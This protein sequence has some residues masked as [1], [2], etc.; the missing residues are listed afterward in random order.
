MAHA[1]GRPV[2][3]ID[4]K[5]FESLCAIQCTYEEICSVLDV[6]DK[7]L[8][9]WCKKTYG[10]SFSEIFGIKRQNGKASLRRM[11]WKLAEKN[12]SMAIFLGKNILNQRDN[13]EVNNEAEL[14]KLDLLL[15]EIRN[16]AGVQN[17]VQS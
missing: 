16:S 2:K 9:K 17:G 10:K 13:I 3:E 5:T 1:G 4:R 14:S 6:N 7:T 12:P 15:Q 8:T 11:Q